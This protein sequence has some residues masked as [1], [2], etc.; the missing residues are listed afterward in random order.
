MSHEPKTDSMRNEDV[1]IFCAGERVMNCG[2]NTCGSQ[3]S[4]YKSIAAQDSRIY[5]HAAESCT[6]AIF[7]PRLPDAQDLW[8]LY[9]Y[10]FCHRVYLLCIERSVGS[11]KKFVQA[12][13]NWTGMFYLAHSSTT[14][15]RALFALTIHSPIA[16]AA[17]PYVYEFKSTEYGP[18]NST[19]VITPAVGG[20]VDTSSAIQDI[21]SYIIAEF[22]PVSPLKAGNLS[23]QAV[24]TD[25]A[26]YW[27]A[28]M[29][30]NQGMAR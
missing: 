1:W 25:A 14:F 16:S 15:C 3:M 22:E 9:Q 17:R 19:M 4:H 28:R 5:V 29:T 10:S 13:D 8:K 24:R 26:H 23:R 2:Y 6:E 7:D 21:Q 20:Q 11:G 27:T 12:N 18:A 30:T